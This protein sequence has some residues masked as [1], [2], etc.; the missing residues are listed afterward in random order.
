MALLHFK[1]IQ[2]ADE[3]SSV[4][5]I[6]LKNFYFEMKHSDLDKLGKWKVVKGE[7]DIE[8]PENIVKR[9]FNFILEQKLKELRSFQGKEAVYIYEGLMPLIGSLYFGIVD[10][11]TNIIEIRPITGCNLNCIFCSVDLC[12]RERDFVVQADYLASEAEKLARLKRKKAKA[13]EIH[14]NAMGEPLL[15]APLADLIKKVKKIKGVKQISIDTNGTLLT[16]EKVDELVKVGLT[17]F[18]ISLNAFSKETAEKIANVVY[19]VENV[20]RICKYIAGKCDILLAP[21]WMQGV[22]DSDI[23]K[24]IEFSKE[25][26]TLRPQQTVPIIG[27]QNFLEYEHG[28]MPAKAIEFDEFYEKLGKL[29]KKHKHKLK[30]RLSREDFGIVDAKVLEKP[31]Q[32]DDY[33]Q[34]IVICKGK[35]KGEKLCSAR[36][37]IISVRTMKK[38]KINVKITRSKYNVFYGREI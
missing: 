33:A 24:I 18:N 16:K 26:K 35:F 5:A 7:L 12:K 37:R 32:N 20:K 36:D 34:A 19:D 30:L 28:K 31:M 38:D 29:E 6:F 27:I 10:R 14:I 11:N 13:L 25:L 3:K 4:R 17:R 2:F 1:D 21:V 23:E 8:G 15:Y 22:N 9:N